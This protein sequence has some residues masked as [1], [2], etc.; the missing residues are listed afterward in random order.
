[1]KKLFFRRPIM[2]KITVFLIH[3]VFLAGCMVSCDHELSIEDQIK[4]DWQKRYGEKLLGVDIYGTYNG[5]VV[6]RGSTGIERQVE[7]AYK[8][9]GTIFR[10]TDLT[11]YL[12]KDGAFY[13]LIDSYRQ[14]RLTS[15]DI[16]KIGEIYVTEIKKGW[17]GS[18]SS[19]NEWYFNSDDILNITE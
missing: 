6:F 2:V 14:G 3:L 12:W 10:G 17:V 16:S 9:A 5:Y 18:E 15:A 8:I 4:Q 11:F 19:F 13:E 7:S 1:M